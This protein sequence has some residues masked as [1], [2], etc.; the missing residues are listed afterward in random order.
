VS[1][2]GELH[3]PRCNNFDN[4]FAHFTAR[5]N[6]RLAAAAQSRRHAA[7]P[8]HA[9]ATA[10]HG[11]ITHQTVAAFDVAIFDR[12]CRR[13]LTSPTAA[14]FGPRYLPPSLFSTLAVF[15]PRCL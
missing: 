8:P 4:K 14:I 12:C 9:A 5:F 2:R 11:I 15:G 13:L 7:G 10:S 3:E 6:A 1:G